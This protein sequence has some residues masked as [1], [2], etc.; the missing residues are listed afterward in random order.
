[1]KNRL[2]GL[3]IF[4][5]A[6]DSANFREAATKLGVSPQVVTRVIRE[7]EDEL[8]ELLFHRSTRGVQ[9]STFGVQLV[10][11]ARMAVSGVDALYHRSD[12]QAASDHHGVVRLAAPGSLGRQFVV[13][14]LAPLLREHPGLVLDLRLSDVIADVV[15]EQIDVGIRIGP[16]RDSRFVARE[17]AKAFLYVVGSPELVSRVGLPKAV[18]DLQHK[19]LTLMIDGNT[20][21]PWPWKFSENRQFIA[22]A[23]AFIT[24]DPESEC[25]A[26]LSGL[27]FGQI[28]GHL[29]LPHI[30]AGRLVT[31]LESAAPKPISLYVYRSQ[32]SPVPARV[33]LVYNRLLEALGTEADLM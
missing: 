21:R 20:G 3:R 19:P 16:M 18:D 7:F 27:G 33:R 29:A 26:V 30:R 24:N 31:A 9:L 6:A 8:G 28:A 22:P 23:P 11:R 32:Q 25:Q 17:V 1:M 2:E 13:D 12:L 14:A 4:V 5:V 10:E 15:E